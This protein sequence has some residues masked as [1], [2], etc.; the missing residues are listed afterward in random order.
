MRSVKMKINSVLISCVILLAIVSPCG[1]DAMDG[2]RG[3]KWGTLFSSLAAGEFDRIPD[4]RSTGRFVE[5]YKKKNEDLRLGEAVIDNV[6]YNFWKGKFYS[7][8]ID[9]KGF[10]N[11]QRIMEYC[12]KSFGGNRKSI[13][14]ET[15][16]YLSYDT[17][18]AEVLVYYQFSRQIEQRYEIRFGRLFIFSKKIDRMIG[19]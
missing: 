19:S 8:A 15:E 5:S 12:D 2:F 17:P 7:V 4:V 6:S 1:A 9:F 14:K 13:G 16:V 18:L 3:I 11:F 10:Y